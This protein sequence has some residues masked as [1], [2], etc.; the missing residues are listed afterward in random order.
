MAEGYDAAGLPPTDYDCAEAENSIEYAI[1]IIGQQQDT[2]NQIQELE[3]I[4][5][6]VIKSCQDL[7]KDYI[8]QKDDFS[9]ELKIEQGM[10]ILCRPCDRL[11]RWEK[12]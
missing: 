8:W 4:R 2:R 12:C 6:N 1:F 9:L 5:K 10:L 11:T 3:N 7:T